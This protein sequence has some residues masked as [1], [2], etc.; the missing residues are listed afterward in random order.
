[1]CP[2]ICV[3]DV[4]GS[5]RRAPSPDIGRRHAFTS[6]GFTAGIV[7]PT[8]FALKDKP[9]KTNGNGT[10]A[11]YSGAQPYSGIQVG[12]QFTGVK[13]AMLQPCCDNASAS[14]RVG[15]KYD[16]C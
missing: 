15:A 6:I 11:S 2:V 7:A 5:D 16:Q 14:L 3:T 9:V 1:M 10:S 13:L 12:L 8:R 4:T